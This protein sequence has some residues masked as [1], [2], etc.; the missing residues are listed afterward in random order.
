MFLLHN[1]LLKMNYTFYTLNCPISF[2][3]G[4]IGL[5]R[6]INHNLHLMLKIPLL[7][8]LWKMSHLKLNLPKMINQLNCNKCFNLSKQIEEINEPYQAN[9]IALSDS[10]IL[11]GVLQGYHAA[12]FSNTKLQFSLK[13]N[14]I[15]FW[16]SAM[17]CDF[18]EKSFQG[19]CFFKTM[20]T[21]LFH[22]GKLLNK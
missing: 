11:K 22:Y 12:Y 15:L 17:C 21:K 13:K 6:K 3:I 9:T 7:Q 20:T 2:Q 19:Y 18:T 10:E 16:W 1:T 14:L 4:N 8:K 5:N